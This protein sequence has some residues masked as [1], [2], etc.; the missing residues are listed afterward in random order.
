MLEVNRESIL[1]RKKKCERRIKKIEDKIAALKLKHGPLPTQNYTYHAG[2]ELGY[3]QGELKVLEDLLEFIEDEL[4][5]M[6]N[7]GANK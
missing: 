6:Y 3:F 1:N 4:L 2:W 5:N 7:E